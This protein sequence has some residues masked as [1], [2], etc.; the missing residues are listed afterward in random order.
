MKMTLRDKELNFSDFTFLSKII[1]L[2]FAL[3]LIFCLIP[4]I[5]SCIFILV[6]IVLIEYCF[7][8]KFRKV[9]KEDKQKELNSL[10]T[11]D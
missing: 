8:P 11:V 7:N 2:L 4:F 3:V 6:L 5:I 10:S 9:L 1:F